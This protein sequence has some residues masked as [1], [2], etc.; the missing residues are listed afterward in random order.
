MREWRHLAVQEL[1]LAVCEWFD[2]SIKEKG[3]GEL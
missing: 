2:V 3:E 1:G